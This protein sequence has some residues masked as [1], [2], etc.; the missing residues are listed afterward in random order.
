ME[1]AEEVLQLLEEF[2]RTRPKDIPKELDDYLGYVAKTGDPMYQ[3]NL[4]KNLFRE[5]LIKVITEFF[6][7]TLT[8]ELPP[9]P[10]VEPFNY[11]RLKNSLLER[12]DTFNSAPFTV[13]RICELLTN[14]R[15]EYNRADKYMRAIEKNILVVSTR[16]PGSKRPLES[17]S[18]QETILNGMPDVKVNESDGSLMHV[19]TDLP[20]LGAP[21]A[22]ND[23]TVETSEPIMAE[24]VNDRVG[25]GMDVN[26]E[27]KT[28]ANDS[29]GIKS[30]VNQEP[31]ASVVESE[32]ACST[33][34]LDVEGTFI[35]EKLEVRD[36]DADSRLVDLENS[37]SN[38]SRPI[39]ETVSESTSNVL[40]HNN[41]IVASETESIDPSDSSLDINKLQVG[42][43]YDKSVKTTVND[44]NE[45][46]STPE[47]IAAETLVL[48]EEIDVP[49]DSEAEASGSIV[50]E[51]LQSEAK[52]TDLGLV[53]SEINSSESRP[54]VQSNDTLSIVAVTEVSGS[55]DSN[56]TLAV[57]C[58]ENEVTGTVDSPTSPTSNLSSQAVVTDLENTDKNC[59]LIVEECEQPDIHPDSSNDVSS[60][61]LKETILPTVDSLESD[62]LPTAIL[63][64]D[65]ISESNEGLNE[66]CEQSDNTPDQ[67]TSNLVKC[68]SPSSDLI[69]SPRDVNIE[70]VAEGPS[71]R[72][73]EESV[74]PPSSIETPIVDKGV[75]TDAVQ[76]EDE[77]LANSLIT[78]PIAEAGL[79][80]EQEQREESVIQTLPS[81]TSDS[82]K[83]MA[84]VEDISVDAG[85]EVEEEAMDVDDSS[86]QMMMI[87]EGENESEPMDQSDQLQS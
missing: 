26:E 18:Q 60:T 64:A 50:E 32:Q 87:S 25:F 14:P 54:I 67:S 10:N 59:P 43:N 66:N 49:L 62:E 81:V 35:K 38:P 73:V 56:D 7:S 28:E 33:S 78:N 71:E 39:S 86:N 82:L 79:M 4:V 77:K 47:D 29:T 13:Q 37:Q 23:V 17:D 76:E 44:E 75:C 30:W 41:D 83:E 3:W 63:Q 46:S 52:I 69:S 12:F 8:V 2:T 65:S 20:Y 15:K 22:S 68:S 55:N 72:V 70:N 57:E 11:D 5:K 45:V 80:Y 1:N 40:I 9:C 53:E 51:S 21:P 31:S 36:C 27:S 74:L 16:E 42:L 48:E 61:P 58:S 85:C 34:D 19:P 24:T 84:T 6:E